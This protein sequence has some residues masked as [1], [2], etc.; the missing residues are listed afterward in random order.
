M[1]EDRKPGKVTKVVLVDK[2]MKPVAAA[3]SA[4]LPEDPFNYGGVTGLQEPPYSPQQLNKLAETHSTHSAALEQKTMD[5]AGTG[6]EWTKLNDAADEAQR[7]ALESWFV[8][9]ADPLN[10]ESTA[11]ILLGTWLDVET[12][13]YGGI[14]IAKDAQGVVRKIFSLPAETFRF[15]KSGRKIAQGTTGRRVWFKRWL[16]N[17]TSV[18]DRKT[19]KLYE[20]RAQ[21]PQEAEPGNEVLIIRKPTRR[22]SWY[23]VPGY[24]SA[25]G[26]AFL[27]LTARDDNIQFFQNRR[28]PRWAIILT[29]LEDDDDLE[30]ALQD[31][32]TSSH[33]EPHRNIIIPIEGDGKITFQKLTDDTKDISF[34]RLQERASAEILLAHRVPPDRL[35]AVRVGPL[36]GNA[37][38][39]A[40]RVYKE[41]VVSTSQ[42]VLANRI[43]RFI[44]AE[45]PVALGSTTKAI[46]PLLPPRQQTPE[47]LMAAQ[48]KVEN[49]DVAEAAP[50]DAV[51]GDPSELPLAWAWKPKDLDITEEESDST[52]VTA[53]WSANLLRLNEARK[54]LNLPPV[55][56][57]DGDKFL[58]QL[59]PEAAAAAASGAAAQ[60]GATAGSHMGL[61]M[62]GLQRATDPR[63]TL[64]IVD[65]RIREVLTREVE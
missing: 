14:E 59:V 6:W 41:G 64:G 21:L 20:T 5:I 3:T 1:A 51:A 11:D 17:D 61:R 25:I 18:I 36:G 19:G 10:D 58:F 12:L 47:E 63:E 46:K 32:L 53:Q 22:K 37:T 26:W 48:P 44:I 40:S 9:L 16:P 35:G 39:A 60:A 55:S 50:Q 49:A 27:S 28:E 34:D 42:E 45:A 23:G 57:N 31:A 30:K 54:K 62:A 15:H 13:G 29:N 8:N 7:L 65:A 56:G 33:S 4:Q 43:N 24:V 38:M 2:E 52:M